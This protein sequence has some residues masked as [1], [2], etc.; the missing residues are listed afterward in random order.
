MQRALL[1]LPIFAFVTVGCEA[2]ADESRTNEMLQVVLDLS[3]GSRVVGTPGIEAVPVQ[4]AYARMNIPLKQILTVTMEADRENASFDLANGDKLK[5]VL[6]L[7]PLKLATV[8]GDISLG[9]EHIK[10]LRVCPAG[11]ALPET[12]RKSLVLYYSFDQDEGESVTDRSPQKN[13]GAVRG[14]RFTP[15]GKSGGALSFD[16]VDDYLDAGN[17]ASLQL[18]ANFTLAAWIRP[19]RTHDSFGIITKSQ[20]YPEQNRRGIEFMLGHDDTLSAYFWDESTRY[21]SGVVKNKTI[22][23]QEWTH[24]VL[25]HDGTLPEHQMRAFINGVPCEMNYGYETV[26]SIPVV[27]NVAEPFRI[28]CMRPGVHHFKGRMDT[29]MIFNRTLSPDEVKTLYDGQ[30]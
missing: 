1:I 28:G 9:V 10:R 29:V 17:P 26:S 23:R 2:W 20:G 6:T 30:K 19:E 8:F 25:L 21:F 27:R 4:T 18:T 12:L 13:N 11:G 14:P 15:E 22:Q 7:G 16:G 3:D 24:V 5:G